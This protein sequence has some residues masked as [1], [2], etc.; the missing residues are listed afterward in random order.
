MTLASDKIPSVLQEILNRKEKEVAALH[1]SLSDNSALTE[2]IAKKGSF[3]QKHLFRDALNLPHG[4][5]AVIAEIK[6]KSPSK[7]QIAALRDPTQIARVYNEGGA[8]CISVLTDLE[9]FG[10]TLDDLSTVVEAQQKAFGD[11]YPGPCPVL[12]KDFIIDEIQIAEAAMAGAG[13]ILLIVTA[14]G[15]ERAKELLEA[16]RAYGLDALVEVHDEEELEIALE[17][18]AD[19]VGVNNR[20]LKNFDENLENSLRLADKIP[21][22]VVS[23]AESG[24]KECVDAWKFRD[25]GYNAVLVG[26]ALVR[27]FA[28]SAD[29]STGYSPGYNQARGLLKAFRS[30]GSVQFGKTSNAAFYGKGE[31][32]TERLG[33]LSI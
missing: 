19:I 2:T 3:P 23:V 20:N 4:S 31:G 15:K 12:R 6:R 28:G 21:S 27:A 13:A 14:L 26:E 16:T 9:G 5:L 25:A 24:I 33:E 22:D 11:K 10:G 29:T 18:G 1:A 8:N 30:K 7:G 32:A 17:I